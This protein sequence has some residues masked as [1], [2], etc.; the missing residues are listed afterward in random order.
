[1]VALQFQHLTRWQLAREIM[2]PGVVRSLILRRRT[3]GCVDQFPAPP[4]SFTSIFRISTLLPGSCCWNAKYP[5]DHAL[6]FSW[7][8]KRSS[9]LIHTLMCGTTCPRHPLSTH[10]TSYA[11]QVSGG[12]ICL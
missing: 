2:R 10:S 1:C 3:G 4:K 11:N 7:S 12:T 6:V 8:S 9:P 5:L